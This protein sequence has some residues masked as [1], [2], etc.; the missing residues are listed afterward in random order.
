M[1]ASRP[2]TGSKGKKP[3]GGAWQ[4]RVA[5]AAAFAR[6]RAGSVSFAVVDERRKLHGFGANASYSSTCIRAT[7]GCWDR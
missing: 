4:A 3:E 5:D 1:P 2:A 6:S 7:G